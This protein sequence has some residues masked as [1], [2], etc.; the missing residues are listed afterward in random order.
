MSLE[1]KFQSLEQFP[2]KLTP[3]AQRK[4][5]GFGKTWS[6]TQNILERELRHLNYRYGSTVLMTAHSPYDVRK[7]GQLRSDVRRPEHPGVVVKFDVYDSRLKRYVQ[8]SFECDQ[9]TEWKDNVRAIADAMEAL[10]K[11]DRYG[12]S[13][14]GKQNAQYEGYKA[15]PSA[16]G[17]ETTRDDAAAFLAT[18]S[19]LNRVDILN[20]GQVRA[21]AYKR[22]V[23]KLHPDKE[24]G[25]HEEFL[26]LQDAIRT[27]NG[28]VQL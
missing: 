2:R 19:G 1:Y 8:M 16:E 20:S 10:R 26:K 27:L 28:A 14:G 12:V 6:E 21:D 13:A 11:V 9:F 17:K 3:P 23:Q 5:A 7:D 4:K 18:H 22:A 15:L 25:S 24:T